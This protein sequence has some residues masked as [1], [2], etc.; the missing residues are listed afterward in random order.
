MGRLIEAKAE[1]RGHRIIGVVDPFYE[2]TVSAAGAAVYRGSAEVKE[3]AAEVVLDFTTPSVV[4]D[5][6]HSYAKIRLPAVIGT[7][8]WYEHIGEVRKLVE[9]AGTSLFYA[10]NF[11]LGVNLFYEIAAAAAAMIDRF[12]EYDAGGFEVHHNKKKD[13]PSGTAKTLCKHILANMTRK[14]QVV[15]DKLDR[16]PLPEELHFASI[17]AGSV[18][19]THTVFFDSGADTIEIRHTARN[20][21]GFAEGAITA[22]EWLAESGIH[23]TGIFEMRDVMFTPAKNEKREADKTGSAK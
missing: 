8:G 6:I 1:E 4:L 11:S 12:P 22:A 5:N 20:R 17:R 7:T 10:S 21:E 3:G 16:P 13:S 19:G 14:T 18:P 15:Y 23:R 9:A 2:G